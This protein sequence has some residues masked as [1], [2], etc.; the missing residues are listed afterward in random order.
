MGFKVMGLIA[1]N[2][3]TGKMLKVT[4]I[5]DG[6]VTTRIM[7]YPDNKVTPVRLKNIAGAL[8]KVKPGDVEIPEHIKLSL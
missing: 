1:Y 2:T 6:I 8:M 4:G 7:T 5:K 3:T